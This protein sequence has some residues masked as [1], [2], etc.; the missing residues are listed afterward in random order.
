MPRTGAVRRLR[1]I[2]APASINPSPA[3]SRELPPSGAARAA[4]RAHVALL[5]RQ[6]G[7]PVLTSDP[8]DLL[9]IDPTLK[10]QRTWLG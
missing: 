3:P 5:A 10:V 6:R 4:S 7:W 1:H 9:A 2:T 8:D